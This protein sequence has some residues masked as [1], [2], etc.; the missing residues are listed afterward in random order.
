MDDPAVG[1][2]I[3]Q[4]LFM[5]FIL[6]KGWADWLSLKKNPCVYYYLTAESI[7]LP[8]ELL[9]VSKKSG[10]F[11]DESPPNSWLS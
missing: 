7:Q 11:L 9:L 3:C 2:F 8:S 1:G 6:Y 4:I 10:Y 5:L